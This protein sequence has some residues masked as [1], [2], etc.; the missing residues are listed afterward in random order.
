MKKVVSVVNK[1][2][3]VYSYRFLCYDTNLFSTK[4]VEMARFQFDISISENTTLEE[5]TVASQEIK[6][7]LTEVGFAKTAV[8]VCLGQANVNLGS[9]EIPKLNIFEFNKA[10]NGELANLFDTESKDNIVF[11][12][13]KRNKSSIKVTYAV[14]KKKTYNK[15]LYVLRKASLNIANVVYAPY[16]LKNYPTN[17]TVKHKMDNPKLFIYVNNA[18]SYVVLS[19]DQCMLDFALS[20][21]GFNDL[22]QALAEKLDLSLNDEIYNENQDAINGKM[23]LSVFKTLFNDIKRVIG[24]SYSIIDNVEVYVYYRHHEI[25]CMTK[26]LSDLLN[27]DVTASAYDGNI[28]GVATLKYK[29]TSEDLVFTVRA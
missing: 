5:L 29:K 4:I 8:V 14:C 25:I 7:K 20:D 18:A 23:I 10:I 28:L 3:S 19:K 24:A 15:V 12:M 13:N 27:T 9:F 22:N 21:V 17:I 16:V 1:Q 11:K 2:G 26:T 6:E